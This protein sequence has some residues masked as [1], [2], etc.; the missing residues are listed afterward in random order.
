[1]TTRR[2]ALRG[3][4]LGSSHVASRMTIAGLTECGPASASGAGHA[5]PKSKTVCVDVGVEI[6]HDHGSRPAT[7]LDAP[8]RRPGAPAWS[9]GLRPRLECV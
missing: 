9:C 4:G 1:M 2:Q 8:G 5:R 7:V 3:H 6:L